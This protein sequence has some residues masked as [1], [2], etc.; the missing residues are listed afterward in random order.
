VASPTKEQ[1]DAAQQFVGLAIEAFQ[2]E[3]GVHAETAIAGTARMAG[4]FLFRSFAFPLAA[5]QPGQ[6]VLSD[7]A[8]EQGPKLIQALGSVLAHIG[9]TLDKS[10]LGA[11]KDPDHQPQL[12]FLA[13]QKRLEP[14]FSRAMQAL[15]LSYVQAAESAAIATAILIKQC[16]PV[17]DPNLAFGIAAYGF[18]EGSKTAPDPVVKAGGAV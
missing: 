14:T 2:G 17:L 13:T 5:I 6:A 12:S 11:N 7:A 4:T 3:R 1:Q 15:G 16:V 9:V 10:K 8:N 18:V